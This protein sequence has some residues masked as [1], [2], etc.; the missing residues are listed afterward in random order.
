MNLEINH[1]QG[2]DKDYAEMLNRVREGRQTESDLEKIKEKIRPYGH[3]DLDEVSLYIVCTNK[4]C[5]KINTNYLDNLPGNDIFSKARHYHPTQKNYKPRICKKE[6]TVGTSSFMNNLRVKVGCK[7][8]LIH[9][10]DTSDGLTNGQLGKLIDIVTTEEGSIAKIIV[11]FQKEKV[12][13]QNREKN[14]QYKVSK[15]YNN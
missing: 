2:R 14:P 3:A 7:V 9:N 13:K 1:R 8:I 5:S 10:I 6:G 11:K 15:R 12:G 4:I